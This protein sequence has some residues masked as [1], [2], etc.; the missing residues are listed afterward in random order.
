MAT[1]KIANIDREMDED[2]VMDRMFQSTNSVILVNDT[3]QTPVNIKFQSD[4]RGTAIN[5]KEKHANLL[6]TLHTIDA[7]VRFIDNNGT[8]YEDPNTITQSTNYEQNFTI[9]SSQR[10]EG[11]IY[12]QCTMMSKQKINQIKHGKTNIMEQLVKQKIF[13]SH[14]RFTQTNEAR[15]G[16]FPSL[17]PQFIYDQN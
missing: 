2:E 5:L 10:Q 17:H 8:S 7:S 14:R 12:V 11:S 3:Y 1:T 16:F 4:R 15:V 13:I 9:D 6:A